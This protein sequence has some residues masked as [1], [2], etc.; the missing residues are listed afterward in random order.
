VTPG[1]ILHNPWL[2]QLEHAS[3]LVARAVWLRVSLTG[4]LVL[5]VAAGCKDRSPADGSLDTMRLTPSSIGRVTD[6]DGQSVNPFKVEHGLAGVTKAHVFIFASTECPISNRYAPEVR[7]LHQVFAP[8]GI[9]F[10]VVY[11]NR[12]ESPEAIRRHFR[13]FEYPCPALLDPELALV[14]K[15][16][17]R[18]TPEAAV[19]GAGEQLL[20]HGRIDNRFAGFGKERPAPTERELETILAAIVEGRKIPPGLSDPSRLAVGCSIAN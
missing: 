15:A 13:E 10:W 18:V 20:Y 14:G 2:S 12:D 8:K 4:A 5:V 17:V 16:M 9:V 1:S 7:R 19:F 11:P 6:M 3:R